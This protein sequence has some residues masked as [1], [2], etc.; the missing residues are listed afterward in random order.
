MSVLNLLPVL[1]TVFGIYMLVKLRFFFIFHPIKTARRLALIIRDKHSQRSLALAL[2]GTLGVG[3]IV[4]V[5]YGISVGGAGSVFWI[6]VSSLFASVIKY[7]ESALA[8]DKKKASGGGMMYV[9]R[10]SLG[11]LGGILSIVYALLCIA[12][13][14][15]MG[16]ALQLQS[17]I[18][19]SGESDRN[20]KY[21]LAIVFTLLVALVIKG[22]AKKIENVT[23]VVIPLSTIIYIILCLKVV[24]CNISRLP[25]TL[26]NI[27][28]SAFNFRSFG[29]GVSS[30]LAIKALKEGYAR[31]LLSNEA[32]AGTSAMAESRS[33]AS[34]CDVGILGMC[35]V[36][37]DT[38]LLCT[39]TGLT[40][41][42]SG[43]NLSQKN[44]VLIVRD[45]LS[46]V[47][48]GGA[49]IILFLLI[50]AFAYATVVCWYYYGLESFRF[51]F[52]KEKPLIF[53]AL[54]LFFTFSG[55]LI[56]TGTLIGITDYILLF[57]SIMTLS[58][59]YKNSERVVRLS[60]QSGL[61]KNSDIG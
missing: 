3:N 57:M 33:N 1:V 25:E 13:A 60:E 20:H 23:A 38:V 36:F 28:T 59:L 19:S 51:V 43:V 44:G 8:A 55:F 61:L 47:L 35:E 37:F 42:L 48:G 52:K 58:I 26:K 24:L 16:S 27:M 9:I 49:G 2:A 32:G 14:L 41:L 7:A 40:V 31:G 6:L 15:S 39:L 17:L 54:F 10:S 18:L 34:P 22:G 21:I 45:A 56:P 50:F 30:F 4:G 11:K 29:G 46:S 5:A 12:L 53:S